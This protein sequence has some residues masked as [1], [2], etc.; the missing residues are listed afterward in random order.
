M[1]LTNQGPLLKEFE[2]R[3]RDYLGLEHIHYVANG[4]VALQLALKALDIGDGEV[5][6]TPFSYVATTSAILLERCEPVFVDINPDTFCIDPHKIEAAI[7]P[8]TKAILAVHVF[9]VPC[10]VTEIDKIAQKHGLKVIYDAAHAF[11]TVYKG[12]SL[13]SYGDI[14]AGSF[15]ATKVFHTVEGGCVVPNTKEVSDKLDLMKRFGHYGDEHFMLGMNAKASEFHAAMGLCNIGH[16]A[17]LIAKRKAIFEHY[18]QLLGGSVKRQ[19][20]PKVGLVY[21]YSYYPIVLDSEERVKAVIQA[22]SAVHV[23]AR[24]YFTPSL[25]TLPYIKKSQPCPKSEDLSSRIVCLPLYDDLAT[26]KIELISKIVN[27]AARE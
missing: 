26:E 8:K 5:I 24:R 17:A 27:E 16:V 10:D 7:T 15:H 22:L 18:D 19:K 13:M 20:R 11:G 12:K 14:S 6:T 25:N 21:N 2:A 23:H 3:L 9:G 4:T 1:Q